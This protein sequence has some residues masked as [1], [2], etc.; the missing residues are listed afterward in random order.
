MIQIHVNPAR[1]EKVEFVSNSD[2]EDDFDQVAWQAI[3]PLVRRIDRTLR[4]I[5]KSVIAED[6]RG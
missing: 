2:I 5:V 4:K 6:Q 1:V 3:R